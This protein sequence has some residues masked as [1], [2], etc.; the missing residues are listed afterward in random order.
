[1][2]CVVAWS[3][4]TVTRSYKTVS[5]AVHAFA[6]NSR[7]GQEQHNSGLRSSLVALHKEK[8]GSRLGVITTLAGI[9]TI[10]AD[11]VWSL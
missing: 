7:D 9:D 11:I 5:S 2:K 4:K 8:K 6:T 10:A 1:M 3:K